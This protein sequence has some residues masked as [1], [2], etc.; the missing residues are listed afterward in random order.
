MSKPITPN[1]I[2]AIVDDQYTNFRIST[3]SRVFNGSTYYPFQVKIGSAWVS[4]IIQVFNCSI[5][6]GAF[7]VTKSQFWKDGAKPSISFTNESTF[8]D[9]SSQTQ[10]LGKALYHTCKAFEF[11]AARMNSGKKISSHIDSTFKVKE[12]KIEEDGEYEKIKQVRREQPFIKIDIITPRRDGKTI[13]N[14]VTVFDINKV[15][16][17][18]LELYKVSGPS[19]D[20]TVSSEN[21]HLVFKTSAKITFTLSLRNVVASGSYLSLM[22][23]IAAATNCEEQGY[24]YLDTKASAREISMF[25]ASDFRMLPEEEEKEEKEE[26]EEEKKRIKKKWSA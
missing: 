18:N 20:E 11:H 21:A 2:A 10:Q 6:R 25:K 15:S 16:G 22:M 24:I 1:E 5:D 8:V 12:K 9:K 26:K 19:G 13:M 3:S 23:K 7:D 4:P 14:A 17:D